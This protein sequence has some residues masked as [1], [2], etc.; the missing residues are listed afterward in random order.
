MR[1]GFHAKNAGRSAVAAGLFLG[2]AACSGILGLTDPTLVDN[3]GSDGGG[4][5]VSTFDGPAVTDAGS[6][7]AHPCSDLKS[8]PNNCGACGHDCL[9]GACSNSVCQ[10]ALVVDGAGKIAPFFMVESADTL[11]FTSYNTIDVIA[12][13][14]KIPK[15]ALAADSGAPAY[16]ILGDFTQGDGGNMYGDY[17]YQL[18][19]SGGT[20][21]VAITA[22]AYASNG[23]YFG[24]IVKCTTGGCATTSPPYTVPGIDSAGVFTIGSLVVYDGYAFTG[25]DKIYIA[26]P[27]LTS[28]TEVP[29]TLSNG[30]VNS[31]II[32][33][34]IAYVAAASGV[35]AFNVTASSPTPVHLSTTY[36]D[37]VAVSGNN[38]YFTSPV[39]GNATVQITSDGV[40]GG[41]PR[42]VASGSDYW[43]TPLSIATD[44]D[45][46]YIAD[47]ADGT[48][49]NTGKLVRCP[50][51][52][53][54]DNNANAVVLSTGA[55]QFGNPRAV[56]VDD[57]A[58]YW[59]DRTG[60]IWKLA[61]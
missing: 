50:L 2:L 33:N 5:D 18:S 11:Y 34:G 22:N 44:N 32:D 59:G 16:T 57:D 6:D 13:V 41:A 25:N 27:D 38:V 29:F 1:S 19:I 31:I 8:D 20:L 51:A 15:S 43:K 52:G 60:K 24:G 17:P 9:G 26:N 3:V 42:T 55:A 23:A 45:Y 37:H 28:P 47:E 21:D 40:D 48:M 4:S 12:N 58:V 56:I 54:G 10:P 46:F 36:A 14:A 30:E 39:T 35:Y 49:P 53:C 61:K 7:G